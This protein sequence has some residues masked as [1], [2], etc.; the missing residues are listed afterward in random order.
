MKS[1]VESDSTFAGMTAANNGKH[2]HNRFQ[3]SE[4]RVTKNFRHKGPIQSPVNNILAAA[5]VVVLCSFRRCSMLKA[6]GP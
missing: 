4:W 2:M 6:I 5:N 3:L 1:P